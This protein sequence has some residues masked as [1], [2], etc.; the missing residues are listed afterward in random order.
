MFLRLLQW[1]GILIWS[2]RDFLNIHFRFRFSFKE[3]LSFSASGEGGLAKSDIK[4]T[5][6]D[7]WWRKKLCFSLFWQLYPETREKKLTKE[8]IFKIAKILCTSFQPKNIGTILF[9]LESWSFKQVFRPS[10]V[11]S[12]SPVK[13]TNLWNSISLYCFW[14]FAFY[15]S[16]RS[17]FDKIIQTH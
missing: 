9:T 8:K 6:G 17:F 14:F 2:L 1:A 11:K 12:W 15:T 10:S 3:N 7:F 16:S 13:K 5:F 4:S